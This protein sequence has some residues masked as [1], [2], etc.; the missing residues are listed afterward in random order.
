MAGCTA[1]QVL[2]IN[3]HRCHET[4][5]PEAW[6]DYKVKCRNCDKL[7]KPKTKGQDTCSKRCYKEFWCCQAAR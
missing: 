4:G 3:G 5:C 6:K 2:M 7:F 1:C